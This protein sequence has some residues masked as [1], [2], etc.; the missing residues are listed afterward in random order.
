MKEETMRRILWVLVVAGALLVAAA[1]LIGAEGPSQPDQDAAVKAAEGVAVSWLAL[2][3]S[4]RY[5]QS[6]SE[7]SSVFRARVTEKEWEKTAASARGSLGKSLSRKVGSAEYTRT[8]PGAPDGEY[9]VIQYEGSFEKKKQAV[10][11]VV[12]MK[13]KDGTWRVSGYF[14]R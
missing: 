11:M 5:A 3:D 13:D 6:W 1:A 12:P 9:V 7:A 10:E 8:L 14:I 2:V 4:G